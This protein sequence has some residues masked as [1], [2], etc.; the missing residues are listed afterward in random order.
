MTTKKAPTPFLS[1]LP[2]VIP[3]EPLQNKNAFG[4][5]HPKASFKV[6]FGNP[7]VIAFRL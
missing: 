6:T 7:A 5:P 3:E 1:P 4:H 2:G